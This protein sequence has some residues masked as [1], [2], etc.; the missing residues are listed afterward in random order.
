MVSSAGVTQTGT[1]DATAAPRPSQELGD[2]LAWKS[3]AENLIRDSGIPYT[4][5]RPT[6][7]TEDPGH[8]PLIMAQGDILAGNVSRAD[9]ANL[10]VQALRWRGATHKTVEIAQGDGGIVPQDWGRGLELL[11][12]DH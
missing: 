8:Q 3:K 10:C 7:L 2:I 5:I 1:S 12:A 11:K 4:I 6:A 9:V